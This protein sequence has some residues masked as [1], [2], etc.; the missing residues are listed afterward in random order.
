M[1]KVFISQ[2]MNGREWDEIMQERERALVEAGKRLQVTVRATPL[3]LTRYDLSKPLF[4]LGDSL[5]YLSNADVAFFCKG[6]RARR[7]CRIEHLA[8]E[9]YGIPILEEENEEVDE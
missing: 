2:P 3:Y 9:E 1:T 4:K 6:W 8:C 7:G 5:Q